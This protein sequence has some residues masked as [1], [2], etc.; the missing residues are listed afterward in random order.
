[1][2]RLEESNTLGWDDAG[3]VQNWLVLA[4]A[5]HRLGQKAKA[6]SCWDRAVRLLNQ[7]DGRAGDIMRPGY[8]ESLILRR[9]AEALLNGRGQGPAPAGPGGR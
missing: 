5:H 4:L 2:R 7:V 1:V 9:E 3:Y 6:R 8:L